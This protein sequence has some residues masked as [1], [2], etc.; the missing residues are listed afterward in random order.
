MA[1]IQDTSRNK[2]IFKN[3]AYLYLRMIL[4]MLVGLYTSRIVLNA[5]GET[6]Y[7]VYNVVGGITTMFVFIN[8]SM[9]VATSRFISF[10][11]GEN[12]EKDLKAIYSQ[13]KIIHLLIALVI[14]VL[15]ETIGLWFLYN[16]LVLP[17][18]R[19]T[20]AF[21]ILQTSAAVIVL[22]IIATPDVALIISHERMS[23][24]AYI[25]IIDVILQ[26][27]VAYLIAHIN[28]DRLILYGGMMM[29]IQL[30]DRMLYLIYCRRNF[31][32]SHTRLFLHKEYF[33]KILSFAGWNLMGN[34][35]LMTIN[36]G[37]S[38][39]LNTFFGPVVNAAMGISNQ[40]TSKLTAF[41]TNIRM[42]INPQITKSYAENDKI[43][44]HQLIKYSSTSCYYLLF[45]FA[46]TLFWI[47]EDIL[48][49]W[50]VK[51]PQYTAIFFKLSIVYLMIKSFSNPIVIGIHATGYIR[52]FQIVEGV[53]MLTT[54]P[55]AYLLMR[56]GLKPYWALVVQIIVELYA[57]IGRVMV[58]MP[59]I[60]YKTSQY[61]KDVIFPC[62]KVTLTAMAPVIMLF[63]ITGEG[64]SL[65]QRLGYACMAAVSAAITILYIGM[66]KDERSKIWKM[67]KH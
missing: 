8:S 31:A 12:K 44:M 54:L 11:I 46:F 34:L 27:I 22:N 15:V 30:F 10:A 26:L 16:K 2:R 45:F 40:V 20:A 32:E 64:S 37:M 42:A 52:K 7:G 66:N 38:I 21:W 28:T 56:L 18:E 61:I 55:L 19:L 51:V 3:T 41:V 57:Q 59:A 6:D 53:L 25:S 13:A 17:P 24:F 33:K 65:G 36:Q 58:T 62:I 63:M 49:L 67:I 50:L 9:S 29:G 39:M 23:S 1:Q 4:V 43:H 5:L 48:Q 60:K 14:I 47:I 35:A